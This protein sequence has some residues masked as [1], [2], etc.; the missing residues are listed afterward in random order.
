MITPPTL[1]ANSRPPATICTAATT[2]AIQ[3]HVLKDDHTRPPSTK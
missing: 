2:M 1:R 3:P